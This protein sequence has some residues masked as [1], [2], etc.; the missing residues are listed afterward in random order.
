MRTGRPRNGT[1]TAPRLL[2]AHFTSCLHPPPDPSVGVFGS[3]NSLDMK[4]RPTPPAQLPIPPSASANALYQLDLPIAADVPNFAVAAH[5][6][7]VPAPAAVHRVAVKRSMEEM[8]P[9]EMPNP[10]AFYASG[11]ALP[12]E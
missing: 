11:G 5:G 6:G 3:S 8:P 2:T 9:L 1:S 4:D 7:A 10:A 12:M